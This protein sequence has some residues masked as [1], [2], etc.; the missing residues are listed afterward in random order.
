AAMVYSLTMTLENEIVKIALRGRS[1]CVRVATLMVQ[2]V[3]NDPTGS[4]P[5]L[6]SW[7]I[8]PQAAYISERAFPFPLPRFYWR[9]L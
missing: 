5:V 2:K 4:K 1:N 9:G 3:L 7:A 8:H 6:C